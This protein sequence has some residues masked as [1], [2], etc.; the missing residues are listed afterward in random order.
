MIN[1]PSSPQQ[2]QG[3]EDGEHALGRMRSMECTSTEVRILKAVLVSDG[4][5]KGFTSYVIQV[6]LAR[7][8]MIQRRFSDFVRLD[9]QI[10]GR[11]PG[12]K[13]PQ[14]PP[15]RIFGSSLEPKFV[16]ERRA[17]LEVYLQNLVGLPNV[18]NQIEMVRF[19]DT[20]S[21]LL[22]YIWNVDR[23]RKMQEVLRNAFVF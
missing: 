7:S 20:E 5:K 21:N 22:L 2:I 13:L 19:L 23:M 18:W 9:Q 15:K 11:H 1:S 6:K 10:G 8:W 3:I 17:L 12:M 4:S 14:L 16:E